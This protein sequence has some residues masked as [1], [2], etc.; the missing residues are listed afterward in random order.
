[1]LDSEEVFVEDEWT[2]FFTPTLLDE[3]VPELIRNV[4]SLHIEQDFNMVTND[5]MKVCKLT[6]D[7][8]IEISDKGAFVRFK[9]LVNQIYSQIKQ[10]DTFNS[11]FSNTIADGVP[12]VQ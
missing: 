3:H 6:R 8:Y 5:I 2:N 12:L 1:M 10:N 4:K 7:T 11:S 9:D